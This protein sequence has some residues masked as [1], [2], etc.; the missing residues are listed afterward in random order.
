MN[1]LI[2][3]YES[4]AD[5]MVEWVALAGLEERA[6][7]RN[8]I[9]LQQSLSATLKLRIGEMSAR[10]A[11]RLCGARST[12]LVRLTLEFTLRGQ[13]RTN[14]AGRFPIVVEPRWTSEDDRFL[15]CYHPRRQQ[16]WFPAYDD[17]EIATNAELYFRDA[18]KDLDDYEIQRLKSNGRDK[19]KVFSLDARP[20]TLE[21][22]LAKDNSG[23]WS[24]L[25]ADRKEKDRP[26]GPPALTVLP[27]IGVDLTPRAIQ[28]TLDVGR[29]R[30]PL[31]TTLLRQLKSTPAPSVILVGPPGCGKTTLLH[32]LVADLVDIDDYPS[33]TNLDR[34]R[35]VWRISGQ[36]LIAGMS[37]IGDWEEQCGK[38]LDECRGRK[39]ILYIEDIQGFGSIGQ[40]RE[41]DRSLADYFRGPVARGEITMI[42]ECTPEA[43]TRLEQEA[44]SF[45]A[46]FRRIEVPATSLDETYQLLFHEA[47]RLE[48]Q[49][50]IRFDVHSYRTTVELT[51]ALFPGAAFP[52]KALDV[53]RTLSRRK[54]NN[55]P[56]GPPAVID[57]LSART[58]LPRSLL[59]SD[60]SVDVRKIE[61]FFASRVM[62]Q[63]EASRAATDVV[64]RVQEGLTD[65]SRP[66]AVLLLTG[67]TGTGKTE[68]AK[69]I[70]RYQ[71]GSL[72]RLIRIDMSEMSGPDGP[73][74]LIGDRYAPD[75]LLTRPLLEQAFC[76]LLLDEIEKAHPSVL[77]LLLQLF[78][79]GR[80]TDAA[81]R[82][83]DA[84]RAVVIMTSNLGARRRAPVGFEEA[85]EARAHQIA[86]AV[87]DFFPPELFNRID[88]VVPFGV[89]DATSAR[90]VAD[91]ELA[92]L[93]AR[94][95]LLSRRVYV[96]TTRA[97]LD[98]VVADGFDPEH[99]A[100]TVK[101]YLESNVT[102]LLTEALTKEAPADMRLLTL[103]VA[104]GQFQV[105]MEGLVDRQPIPVRSPLEDA[106]GWI[107]DTLD[108]Q[109]ERA[110]AR[111]QAGAEHGLPRLRAMVGRCL[112][113]PTSADEL[114]AL[115]AMQSEIMRL[116]SLSAEPDAPED[117][118]EDYDDWDGQGALPVR[119]DPPVAK[120]PARPTART[121]EQQL[122]HIARLYFLARELAVVEQTGRHAVRVIV[123]HVGPVRSTTF[124]RDLTAAYG[125]IDDEISV[126]RWA[127]RLV[128][129][130]RRRGERDFSSLE[131]EIPTIVV[132]DLSGPG[133]RSLMRF[134]VGTHALETLAEGATLAVV[135]TADDL[136]LETPE[137]HLDAYE[138]DRKRFEGALAE[139]AEDLPINPD[140]LLPLTRRVRLEPSGDPSVSA[141]YDIEDHA[142][143]TTYQRR[144]ENLRAALRPLW[145][146]AMS[147]EEDA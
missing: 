98:K 52:G 44:P 46:L 96:S 93:V 138:A 89:L 115:E 142:L 123:R 122:D 19:L 90:Q 91:K 40:T 63:P 31:R 27:K 74:R 118:W 108:K 13:R 45:A 38:L 72:A 3:V 97:V 119:L 62:G 113:D 143:T 84:R 71:Y 56:I 106:S 29:P 85:P 79:E 81:G 4:K 75:G 47:R 25:L 65:A 67:P 116:T 133:V 117:A 140:R 73:T 18:W 127:A 128:D 144:A 136:A 125:V 57:H 112:S 135:E 43:S 10:I 17:D 51:D 16:A 137:A 111:L 92:R 121:E 146:L 55:K 69:A 41:S 134:E 6:T 100:R 48:L 87:Q 95:G 12:R 103:Y 20:V 78:D 99:G 120:D 53:V 126:G 7:G 42:G 61:G 14:V 132:F 54:K 23:V 77:N 139:G 83:A 124:V 94:R 80:L 34:I 76:T 22:L 5:G 32:R 114:P 130:R 102:S 88:R 145:R 147:G 49:H 131:V 86:R 50:D 11:A 104:N 9:K 64:V 39:I 60:G 28:K 30:E 36:R 33:H 21:S 37:Y 1:F 129:G 82:V 8:P 59:R 66:Y 107:S 15:V 141:S 110:L 26:V 70:A 68:L 24:D 101:R 35:H 2:P 109:V 58:G 105:H